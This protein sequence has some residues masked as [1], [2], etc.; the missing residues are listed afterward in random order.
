MKG[1]TG[2]FAH[3]GHD[4]VFKV[5]FVDRKTLEIAVHPDS[6]VI[7]KAPTGATPDRIDDR[8]RKRARW[9][10][11]QLDYFRQFEPRTPP[12][13]Y[14][15]GESHLYLGRQYRLKLVES[16][17]DQ[18]KLAN[19]Y[20]R[21]GCKDG[22]DPGRVKN[23]LESWYLDRARIQFG[24]RFERRWPDFERLE[25]PRPRLRIR[26]MKTRW[27]SLSRG[28]SLTLNPDLI[29]APGECLD[30]VIAHEL[31]HLKYHHHGP[32]FYRLLEKV[33]P[34]WERR[35]HKLETALAG[36]L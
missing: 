29:R 34:D 23:L 2:S 24:E 16:D 4:I 3:G 21:I 22:N 35:K 36:C 26:R 11:K 14:I 28:G 7:V 18:V 31:C 9:I 8:V 13:R 10:G 12:R 32:D 30:Y 19:G 1:Y 6:S 20:F 5:L 17:V 15:G 27:G 25:L 33:T